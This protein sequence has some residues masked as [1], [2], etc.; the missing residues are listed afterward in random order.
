MGGKAK[1][2]GMAEW[3]ETWGERPTWTSQQFKPQ[4]N[5]VGVT[6]G[7][8]QEPDPIS[9]DWLGETVD[10]LGVQSGTC[11]ED[12]RVNKK[13]EKGKVMNMAEVVAR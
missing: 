13:N 5:V 11:F 8:D 7:G 2:S 3:G 10:H 9:F 1:Q 4:A 6:R 12:L